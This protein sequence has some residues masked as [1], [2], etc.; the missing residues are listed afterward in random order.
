[1]ELLSVSDICPC[2]VLSFYMCKS[3]SFTKFGTRILMPSYIPLTSVAF[4]NLISSLCSVR[5]SKF[6]G[7]PV[8]GLMSAYTGQ[9]WQSYRRRST[10][11]CITMNYIKFR[12]L[13]QINWQEARINN[14]NGLLK[15]AHVGREIQV[16]IF[17]MKMILQNHFSFFIHL[18]GY[19][20]HLGDR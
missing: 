14:W 3:H 7:F 10:F 9:I 19:Y 16:C 12:F 11:L 5:C 8:L 17:Y 6:I 20:M 13:E 4:L 18:A 15:E 1:M 2:P